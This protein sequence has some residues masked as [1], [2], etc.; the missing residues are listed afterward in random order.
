MKNY[1]LI[2]MSFDGEYVK[3]SEHTTIEA[4]QNA[5]AELGSKWYFYPFSIIVK[6]QTVKET[7][8]N[9]CYMP[10]GEPVLSRLLKG[11]RLKT[12]KSIFNSLSKSDEMQGADPMLF[13]E[14]LIEY[15]ET[16]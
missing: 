5:S 10:S 11:K 7:G 16:I 3:D 1:Q 14:V 15:L 2:Q 13:E 12:V 6:G 8:G 9:I 4:A